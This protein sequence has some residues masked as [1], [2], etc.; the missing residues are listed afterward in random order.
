MDIKKKTPHKYKSVFNVCQKRKGFILSEK[1]QNVKYNFSKVREKR[2]DL[3]QF[4]DKKRLHPKKNPKKQLD[5]T[6]TSP[7]TSFTQLLPTDLGRSVG[8]ATATQLV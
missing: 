4:Y 7:R 3:I 6:K 2:R 5:N 8:I 1:L